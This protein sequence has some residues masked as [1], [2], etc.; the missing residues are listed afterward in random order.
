MEDL[1]VTKGYLQQLAEQQESAGKSFEQ[2]KAQASG[3]AEMINSTHGVVCARTYDAVKNS[4]DALCAALTAM[5][6]CT[7][8]LASSLRKAENSYQATDDH[9]M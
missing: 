1:A 8:R 7:D 4:E 2:A 5:K 9:V 3:I 6:D